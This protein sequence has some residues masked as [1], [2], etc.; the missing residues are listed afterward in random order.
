MKKALIKAC[1][2]GII[3]I[4]SL[5]VEMNFDIINLILESNMLDLED[6]RVELE[7]ISEDQLNVKV[8]DKDVFEREEII[9]FKGTTKDLQ[10]KQNKQVKVFIKA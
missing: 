4:L 5:N 9:K 1:N 8:Y 3:K 10:V 2:Y 6:A 7:V